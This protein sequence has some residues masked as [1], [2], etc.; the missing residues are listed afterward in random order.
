M[1]TRDVALITRLN[2][3]SELRNLVRSADDVQPPPPRFLIYF[4]PPFLQDTTMLVCKC[5]TSAKKSTHGAYI[6]YDNTLFLL[7][8]FI[9]FSSCTSIFSL[10]ILCL[11]AELSCNSK[12]FSGLSDTLW[13]YLSRFAVALL[14]MKWNC[15]E[16]ERSLY[17]FLV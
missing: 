3:L 17:F 2:F 6:L 8:V 9:V 5:S 15:G 12:R 14:F 1:A 11:T 13:I 10:R 16:K 4:P 7:L